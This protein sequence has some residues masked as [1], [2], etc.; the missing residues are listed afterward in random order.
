MTNQENNSPEIQQ[1]VP[2]PSEIA[3]DVGF[4]ADVPA[5]QEE[6]LERGIGVDTTPNQEPPAFPFEKT[7]PTLDAII[8]LLHQYDADDRLHEFA[9]FLSNQDLLK[10]GINIKISEDRRTITV[11]DTKAGDPTPEEPIVTVD[12]S[13]TIPV[14]EEDDLQDLAFVYSNGYYGQEQVLAI[15]I[16]SDTF[17]RRQL[18]TIK[19]AVAGFASGKYGEATFQITRGAYASGLQY[20]EFDQQTPEGIV[21]GQVIYNAL[22]QPLPSYRTLDLRALDTLPEQ[23]Y[24]KTALSFPSDAIWDQQSQ[25]IT[26]TREHDGGTV[27]AIYVPLAAID[28]NKL[29]HELLADLPRPVEIYN[30]EQGKSVLALEE[31]FDGATIH[32]FQFSH[33]SQTDLSDRVSMGR[34]AVYAEQLI[35]ALIHRYQEVD[36]VIPHPAN[37]QSIQLL[38]QVVEIQQARTLERQQQAAQVSTD[39]EE[40]NSQSPENDEF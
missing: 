5:T 9:V 6:L 2:T 16:A 25:S 30:N 14:H 13:F 36:K 23:S 3:V 37:E 31:T 24:G 18:E 32:T 27:N 29:Y 26:L 40:P 39:E 12:A 20:V 10:A 33:G 35:A 34:D 38:K 1:D 17:E 19:E 22:L 11:I 21:K 7:E 15:A 28:H 4:T 8:G